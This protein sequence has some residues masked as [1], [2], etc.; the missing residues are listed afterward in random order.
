MPDKKESEFSDEKITELREKMN[1]MEESDRERG[2]PMYMRRPPLLSRTSSMRDHPQNKA[3]IEMVKELHSDM[4]EI[5]TH[6]KDILE[7][8]EKQNE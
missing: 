8:L 3:I 6:L 1:D 4:E 2:I 5:K 7:I